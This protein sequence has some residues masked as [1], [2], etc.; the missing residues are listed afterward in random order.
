VKSLFATVSLGICLMSGCL[1]SEQADDDLDAEGM[2]VEIAPLEKS[3]TIRVSEGPALAVTCDG[4]GQLGANGGSCTARCFG[5]SSARARCVCEEN[6]GARYTAY[7]PWVGAGVWS[8]ARCHEFAWLVSVS[9]EY[10]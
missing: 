4:G 10:Q 1:A 3:D 7:G 2:E 6:S 8:W 5:V 9:A